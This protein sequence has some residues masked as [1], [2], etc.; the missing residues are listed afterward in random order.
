ML[1]SVWGSLLQERSKAKE[2]TKKQSAAKTTHTVQRKDGLLSKIALHAVCKLTYLKQRNKQ[3]NNQQL[4][5]HTQSREKMD[6]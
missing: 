4:K 1:S 3:R 5:P 6:Y 2:Q